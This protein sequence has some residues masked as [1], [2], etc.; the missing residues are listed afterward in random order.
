MKNKKKLKKIKE[1]LDV[2]EG[3]D[4]SMVTAQA[5]LVTIRDIVDGTAQDKEEPEPEFEPGDS[6]RVDT[7]AAWDYE[8]RVDALEGH[9]G[10]KGQIKISTWVEPKDI[11]KT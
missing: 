9:G 4:N 7:E 1:E 10:L 8:F 3:W 6:V 2:W 5:T 11:E